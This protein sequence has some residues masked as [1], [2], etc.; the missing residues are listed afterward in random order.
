MHMGAG[1]HMTIY[2]PA[3]HVIHCCDPEVTIQCQVLK[4]LVTLF[5]ESYPI[6]GS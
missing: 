6:S 3:F 2:L 4:L 1:F 5:S